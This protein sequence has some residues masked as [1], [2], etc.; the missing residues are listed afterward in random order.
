MGARRATAGRARG[1]ADFDHVQIGLS[2]RLDLHMIN[3]DATRAR[4]NPV[5]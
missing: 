3:T 1:S 2:E 4:S 5:S